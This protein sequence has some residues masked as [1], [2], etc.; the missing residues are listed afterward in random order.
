MVA[1]ILKLIKRKR[2]VLTKQNVLVLKLTIIFFIKK[3]SIIVPLIMFTTYWCIEHYVCLD[4]S[5]SVEATWPYSLIINPIL[6]VNKYIY[7]D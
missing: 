3:I 7:R 4:H 2:G 5:V 1:F 6:F